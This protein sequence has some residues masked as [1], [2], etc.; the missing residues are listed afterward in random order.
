MRVRVWNEKWSS[1]ENI[2]HGGLA[3]GRAY[4]RPR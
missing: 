3:F 2:T 4:G 1:Y